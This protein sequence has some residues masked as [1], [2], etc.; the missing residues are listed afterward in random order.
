MLSL[1]ISFVR[2]R[3][4]LSPAPTAGRRGRRAQI[5]SRLAALAATVRLG[6][7]GIEHDGTLA[8]HEH[9]HTVSRSN[10]DV[11]LTGCST[12]L[13]ILASNSPRRRMST[14]AIAISI[15]LRSGH[16]VCLRDI[17]G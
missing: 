2:P 7:D 5:L 13:N 3:R 17:R 12:T 4:R 9:L 10:H 8:S 14:P 6:L 1:S 11:A 16:Q 15:A